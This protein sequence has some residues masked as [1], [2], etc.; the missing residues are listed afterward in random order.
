MIDAFENCPKPVVAALHGTALGGGF[1]IQRDQLEWRAPA[2]RYVAD[3]TL[4]TSGP[5]NVE[6][7]NDTEDPAVL[8]T[9][10]TVHVSGGPLQMT[11][12]VNAATAY[13]DDVFSG[14]GPFHAEFNAPPSGQRL[15][16]RVWSPGN[17]RV[18]VYGAELI[19]AG[20]SV[21]P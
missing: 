18:D 17:T 12:P 4:A 5:V 16:V 9:R 7:W 13:H 3:V 11:M 15:E 20:S 1:D 6:V 2:G 21:I 10:R 14:F 19:P 8:L